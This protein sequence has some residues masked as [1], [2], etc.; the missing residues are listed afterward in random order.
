MAAKKRRILVTGV[1]RWWGALLVQRLLE[2]KRVAEVVAIDTAAP[3]VDLGDAD[4][5]QLDIRHTLI[6]KLVRAVGVDTV[7]HCQTTIDSADQDVRL[8]HEIN[9][10][11]SLNLLAGLAGAD[12]PVRRVVFKSSAHVYGSSPELPENLTEDERLAARSSHAFVRD[13]V[14]AETNLLEFSIRNPEIDTVA[15]RFANSLSP[16]E[17]APLARYFDLPVVPTVA[18]FDPVIQLIHRDDCIE[19]LARAALGTARGPFNVAAPS[20][21]PLSRLLEGAGKL[22]APLLPPAGGFILSAVLA[23]LGLTSLS[24]QLL[25]LL[26]WGRTLDTTRARRD[27]GFRPVLDTPAALDEYIQQRRVLQ[28]MPHGRRYLYER[29]LEEYIHAR[30]QREKEAADGHEPKLPGR[31][32]VSRE[33][34]PQEP[35]SP[36]VS[37]ETV[38]RASAPSRPRRR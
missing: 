31:L 34:G 11:G 24:P 30:R 35:V 13:I 27:L 26:R 33:I 19:A 7:V 29:Q 1:A 3:H 10:I 37:R 22:H 2:D 17:P 25:D 5:L 18:G 9:V 12:T 38:G 32:T 14:E 15:L 20:A 23:R 28:F 4:F 36:T 16:E 6:G 8:A 21:L